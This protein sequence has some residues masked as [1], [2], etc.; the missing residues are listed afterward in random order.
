MNTIPTLALIVLSALAAHADVV[1]EQDM[2]S[3]AI[4][5][6]VVTK[7]K[8]DLT[9]I[10]LTSP[11]GQ[12]TS[13]IN[14]RTGEMTTILHA[15]KRIVKSD[16]NATKKQLE[17]KLK[18]AGALSN[19]DKP[20]ATGVTETV[21]QWIA[22]VY[23]FQSPGMN[24]KIWAVKDFPNAQTI[25]KEMKKINDASSS[26]IGPSDMDVPGIAVKSTVVTTAGS[27]STTTLVKAKEEAVADSEFT[28]PTGYTELKAPAQLGA[29]LK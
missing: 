11:A 28:L 7:I 9:R 25:R 17:A 29:P 23:E 8:G 12:M 15:Y 6:R 4:N 18:A 20:K 26:R 21:G 13:I 22:D 27:M 16:M 1:I 14:F 10:D 2:V 19:V 3:D 5:G 24:G